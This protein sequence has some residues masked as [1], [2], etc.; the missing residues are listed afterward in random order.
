MY[1]R[2]L[3]LAWFAFT[4]SLVAAPEKLAAGKGRFDFTD[5]DGPALPVWYHAPASLTPATP[6]LFVMH[7]QGRNG[8]EYRDQWAALSEKYG[9]LLLVPTFSRED[10]PSV[11]GY[12]FG[13][14]FAPGGQRRP[15]SQWGYTAI[16]KIFDH[17]NAAAGLEAKSYFI[18]GHSAGA[19]FVHRMPFFLPAARAAKLVPANAGSYML[20]SFDHAFPYGLKGSGLA[21]ADLKAALQKA[22]VVFLGTADND[23]NDKSMSQGPE[24]EAQGLHRF[25]RGL[26]YFKL[27]SEQAVRLHVPFGWHIATAAG[28][29]HSNSQMAAFAAEELFGKN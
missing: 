13:N 23:P 10:F 12:N 26:N 16:E 7:G 27:A 18:Y 22:V 2:V 1:L 6:I 3:A 4:A 17:T 5:W 19:Q 24:L 21:E 25:A 20:P 29:A 15:V 28:V 11:A 9:F 14:V 8:D